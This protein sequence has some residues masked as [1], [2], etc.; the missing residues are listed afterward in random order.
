[1][2]DIAYLSQDAT[3]TEP[4]DIPLTKE[5]VWVLGKRYSAIQGG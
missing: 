1:M 3:A 2:F 4:N 5:P